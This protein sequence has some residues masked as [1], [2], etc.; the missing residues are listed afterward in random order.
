MALVVEVFTSSDGFQARRKPFL[1]ALSPSL[2]LVDGSH[3]VLPLNGVKGVLLASAAIL[4]GIVAM[5]YQLVG[6]HVMLI[7]YGM[8]TYDFII[9]EQKREREKANKKKEAAAAKLKGTSHPATALGRDINSYD[10]FK[11]AARAREKKAVDVE[12]GF[13]SRSSDEMEA[14]E[15]SIDIKNRPHSTV[16]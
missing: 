5:V 4:G 8:T 9:A 15:Y 12:K 16:L 1:Q 6:F 7:I 14:V 10:E 11:A 2:S 13:S 3:F